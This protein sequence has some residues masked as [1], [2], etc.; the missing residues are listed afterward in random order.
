MTDTEV[1]RLDKAFANTSSA[2]K[3][4]SKTQPSEMMQ[5]GGFLSI[6][7]P[8]S[9]GMDSCKITLETMLIKIIE[10]DKDL[11]KSEGKCKT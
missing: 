2:N 9:P 6:F 10:T 1:S 3:K 5:V 11:P 8:F 7:P 4:L